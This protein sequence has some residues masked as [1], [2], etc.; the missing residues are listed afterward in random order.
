MIADGKGNVVGVTISD[1]DQSNGVSHV[2]DN[3]LLLK[4]YQSAAPVGDVLQVN[5]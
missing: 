2:F 4:S 3:V 1:M 5:N